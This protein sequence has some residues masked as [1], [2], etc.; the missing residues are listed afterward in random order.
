MKAVILYEHRT[1]CFTHSPLSFDT[2]CVATHQP[3]FSLACQ[4]NKKWTLHFI[5]LV[6]QNHCDFESSIHQQRFKSVHQFTSLFHKYFQAHLANSD[7]F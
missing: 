5:T 3:I 1:Y 4:I 2:L 7:V 6:K